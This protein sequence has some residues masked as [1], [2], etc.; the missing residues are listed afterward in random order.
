MDQNLVLNRT[1]H[2]FVICAFNRTASKVDFLAIEAKGTKMV[3]AHTLKEM[4]SK[5]KKPW[6]IILLV[7]A[8]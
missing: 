6:W 5:L 8:G 7:K 3:T 4:V 2:S 1:D